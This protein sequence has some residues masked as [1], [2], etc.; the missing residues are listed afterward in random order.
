MYSMK[1]TC[2]KVGL[3]YQTLKFYCNE[4]LVPHL[5]RDSNNYRVFDDKDVDWIMNLICLKRC[6][7][8]IENMKV[9]VDLIAKGD[10]SMEQRREMLVKQK[11]DLMK[12]QELL[13]A[14]LSYIDK[15]LKY[16]D[17][18]LKNGVY[19]VLDNMYDL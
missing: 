6:G 14:N 13:N 4:G 5:K 3:S 19:K 11:E 17:D 15:K 8:S 2:Q 12:E 1:D 7:M 16:Y 9:Y 18:H 10:P